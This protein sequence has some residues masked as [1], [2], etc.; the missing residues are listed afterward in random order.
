MEQDISICNC[1]YGFHPILAK[2]HKNIVHHGGNGSS[3]F[4]AM[5]QALKI[6]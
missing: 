6:L 1:S 2:L 5:D 3:L 4:L